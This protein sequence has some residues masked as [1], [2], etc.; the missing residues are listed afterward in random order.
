MD[1][2]CL[3]L[4]LENTSLDLIFF[5]VRLCLPITATSA[6]RSCG[7]PACG[8]PLGTDLKVLFPT[9][10]AVWHSQLSPHSHSGGGHRRGAA[11]KI[12][13][14]TFADIHSY[15]WEPQSITSYFT[16]IMNF[17]PFINISQNKLWENSHLVPGQNRKHW[18]EWQ[19]AKPSSVPSCKAGQAA[20]TQIWALP[21]A[22]LR[23]GK[24]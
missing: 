3:S 8:E 22:F 11:E 15:T 13:L 21:R 20:T 19:Q 23:R 14:Q 24:K 6:Q 10:V 7:C 2:S 16:L 1:G 5:T 4:G 18:H 17:C 12:S 9:P